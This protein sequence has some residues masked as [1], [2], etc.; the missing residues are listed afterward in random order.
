MLTWGTLKAEIQA[1]D[2]LSEEVFASASEIIGYVNDAL[3]SIEKD[4]HAIGGQKYFEDYVD[5]AMVNGTADYSI[6]TN[7]SNIYGFK[8]TAIHYIS[9]NQVYEIMPLKDKKDLLRYQNNYNSSYRYRY[10]FY[11]Q[12]IVLDSITRAYVSGGPKITLYPTPAETA[13]MRVYYIR[14]VAKVVDE[15][16]V[17]EI[18]EANEFIK[19]YVIEKCLNKERL[20]Q[21][22]QESAGVMQKRA[23]LIDSLTTMFADDNN[24]IEPDLGFYV[25]HA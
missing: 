1:E 20:N 16:S 3:R 14:S 22:A 13:T 6:L 24:L 18:P 2:D 23:Q 21:D 11:N 15:N 10:K 19:A 12:P 4:I 17:I 8:I 7:L 5:L 9:S 25:S